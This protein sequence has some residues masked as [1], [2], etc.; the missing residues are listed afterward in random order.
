[1][2]ALRPEAVVAGSGFLRGRVLSFNDPL[3]TI[4]RAR[5]SALWCRQDWR[6]YG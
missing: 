3:K 5:Q 1:M 4:V 6:R 2:D